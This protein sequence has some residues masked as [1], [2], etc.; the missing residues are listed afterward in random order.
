VGS[1]ETRTFTRVLG[2]HV[3]SSG[4]P[5]A[6]AIRL[7]DATN[8]DRL[9]PAMHASRASLRQPDGGQS[10]VVSGFEDLDFVMVRSVYEPMFVVNPP[11]P[12]PR[13]FSLERFWF[14]NP[15]EWVAL[16]FSDESGDPA[17]RLAVGSQPKEKILPSIGIEVDTSH[18]S[19]P[20]ISFSSSIDLLYPAGEVWLALSRATASMS[21]RAF[22]GERS[23]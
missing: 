3:P 22:S 7:R 12:V 16:D 17:G 18:S 19:P 1:S 11:G 14:P 5:A 20:A 13:Q 9:R 15:C 21:R 4:T 23:R 2:R 6:A 10:V 8:R